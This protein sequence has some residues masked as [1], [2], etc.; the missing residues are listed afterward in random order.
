[1][2]QPVAPRAEELALQAALRRYS[3][4]GLAQRAERDLKLCQD[5]VRLGDD[6]AVDLC[7]R[8]HA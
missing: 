4:H 7:G 8:K 3:R 2:A 5:D 6:A 1:M